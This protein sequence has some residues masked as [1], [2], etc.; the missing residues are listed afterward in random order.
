MTTVI[1]ATVRI[2]RVRCSIV[3]KRQNRFTMLLAV[4]S[5]AGQCCEDRGRNGGIDRQVI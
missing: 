3:R 5:S 4:A 2:A 1:D